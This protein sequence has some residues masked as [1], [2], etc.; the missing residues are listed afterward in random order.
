[1]DVTAS[2]IQ[3]SWAYTG[4]WDTEVT[5]VFHRMPDSTDEQI[6]DAKREIYK[7]VDD[8][9]WFFVIDAQAINADTF[10]TAIR[11]RVSEWES[12]L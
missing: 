1:M 12:T 8:V 3:Y 2:G 10:T 11:Q 9:A 7:Y 4:I 6:E 5:C